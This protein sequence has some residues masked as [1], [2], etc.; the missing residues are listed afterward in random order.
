M[1]STT[2]IR[3]SVLFLV[4]PTVLVAA[5]TVKLEPNGIGVEIVWANGMPY[6][7]SD[8]VDDDGSGTRVI[9][10]PTAQ[11]YRRNERTTFLLAVYNYTDDEIVV[12]TEDVSVTNN[13]NEPLEIV[14][15]AQRR[16]EV[17]GRIAMA[18]ALAGTT[19]MT[20]PDAFAGNSRI[21]REPTIDQ[22]AVE[23]LNQA[24]GPIQLYFEET[25]L[26]PGELAY[27]IVEAYPPNRR[28][29]EDTVNFTIVIG[30]HTHRVA[31]EYVRID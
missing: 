18:S 28:A 12:S 6:V 27:G 31:F 20:R 3:T 5:P 30:R 21:T 24:L 9:V 15:A 23:S 16:A 8:K 7:A 10:S 2:G 26:L 14:S 22:A 25:T 13:K 4:V 11:S 17:H 29:R 19:P 1:K